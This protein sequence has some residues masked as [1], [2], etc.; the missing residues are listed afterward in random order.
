MGIGQTPGILNTIILNTYS[1]RNHQPNKHT[2]ISI[3]GFDNIYKLNFLQFFF[4]CVCHWIEKWSSCGHLLEHLVS[5]CTKLMFRDLLYTNNSILNE[6][7][8][9]YR[10]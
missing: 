6:E 4:V 5:S 1:D 2:S 7:T 9:K 8:V 3:F 10:K